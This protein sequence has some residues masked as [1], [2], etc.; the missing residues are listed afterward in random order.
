MGCTFV[1]PAV[2]VIEVADAGRG[3]G[4]EEERD[5]AEEAVVSEEEV[6]LDPGELTIGLSVGEEILES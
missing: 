6:E 4:R 3:I 1:P 5:A 2:E